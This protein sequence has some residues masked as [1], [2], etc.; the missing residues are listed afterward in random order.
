MK[1]QTFADLEYACRKRTTKRVAF[2]KAMDEMIPQA[3]WV[4]VIRPFYP[5]GNRGHPPKGIEGIALFV[6]SVF[7]LP[8]KQ[9]CSSGRIIPLRLLGNL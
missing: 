4:D 1:Q 3:Y 8:L 2:L 6:L 5:I 9:T 7:P